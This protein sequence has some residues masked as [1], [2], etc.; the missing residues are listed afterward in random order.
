MAKACV[1]LQADAKSLPSLCAR[2]GAPATD[3]RQRTFAW[4]WLR[5]WRGLFFIVVAVAAAIAPTVI[6]GRDVFLW[7]FWGSLGL[8]EVAELLTTKRVRIEMPF[9]QAHLNM[10]TWGPVIRYAGMILSVL[11]VGVLL[12]LDVPWLPAV[13]F[14]ASALAFVLV[15]A[16]V[17]Q[18]DAITR[19]EIRA[20][21]ITQ[22]TVV[23]AGLA[24]SFAAAV[25]VKQAA[26]TVPA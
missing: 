13:L 24:D 23:L 25:E 14:G 3:S 22:S 2:C 4:S 6:A 17:V 26:S 9:C 19:G 10:R 11:L 5:R 8:L 18:E 7:V 1:S 20:L 16:F 21:N 15:I 12:L